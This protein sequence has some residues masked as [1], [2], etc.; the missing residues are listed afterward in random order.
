MNPKAAGVNR[1]ALAECR[2]VD[3]SGEISFFPGTRYVVM[4]QYDGAAEL[5]FDGRECK[6]STGTFALYVGNRPCRASLAPPGGQLL[7]LSFQAVPHGLAEEQLFEESGLSPHA[8]KAGEC[9][10]R[11]DVE[12]ESLRLTLRELQTERKRGRGS[13][14]SVVDALSFVLLLKVFRSIAQHGHG[15]GVSYVAQACSYILAHY[16][17]EISPQSIAAALGIHRTYLTA[18]FKKHLGCTP[19]FYLNRLRVTQA[20]A[21]LITT[22][23]SITDIAFL[24]GFNSRQ[25]FHHTFMEMMHCT[26][27]QYRAQRPAPSHSTPMEQIFRPPSAS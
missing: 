18:L 21:Y 20:S 26:P 6:L 17:Q 8:L 19:S 22:D 13:S 12:S 5:N 16:A 7:A 25:H 9:Y 3:A 10:Q 27:T 23:R 4:Y 15:Y 14:S 1:I 2:R 24:S 11:V